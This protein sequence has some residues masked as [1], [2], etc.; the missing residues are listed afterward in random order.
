MRRSLGPDLQRKAVASAGDG[1]NGG[2]TEDLAQRRY[3]HLEVAVL[4]HQSRPR[5]FE[6]LVLGNQALA[7]LNES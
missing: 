7:S 3:L 1:G 2:L 4:D 5:K 6:Q